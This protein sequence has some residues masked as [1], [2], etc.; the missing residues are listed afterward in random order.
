MKDFINYIS[1]FSEAGIDMYDDYSKYC[2][3]NIGFELASQPLSKPNGSSSFNEDNMSINNK[4]L[5]EDTSESRVLADSATTLEQLEQIVRAFNGCELKKT[6]KSTVFADGNGEAKIMFI[7]EAP[8]A[9]EDAQGIPFCGQSGKLLDNILKSVK[10][11]RSE[12]YITNAIFWR[13]PGNRRPTTKE[14]TMCRPFLEKHISLVRPG[15]IILV[16]STAVESLLGSQVSMHELRQ[17]FYD[18][19]NQY[20]DKIIKTAVIFHPSYLLRQPYKKKLMWYD[21]YRLSQYIKNSSP[22]A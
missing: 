13:P 2:N 14:I 8:G 3:N 17:G 16:G 11:A 21:I 6:A 12:V 7:G 15:L 1:Y 19:N 9:S 4:L 20:L 5:I 10:V 18:Y 22:A